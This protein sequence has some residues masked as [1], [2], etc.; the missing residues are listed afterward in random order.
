MQI[1]VGILV[2][3]INQ[4]PAGFSRYFVGNEKSGSL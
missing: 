1:V 4:R 2:F 3:D